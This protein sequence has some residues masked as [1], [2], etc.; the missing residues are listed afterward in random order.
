[1]PTPI[2]PADWFEDVLDFHKK[3]GCETN[4][5]PCYPHDKVRYLRA[6]LIREEMEELTYMVGCA[7]LTGIADGITDSIYVLIGMAMAYG[8]DLRPIWDEVHRTNMRKEGG[9]T[10]DDGKILKPNGWKPPRIKEL[11][12]EQD[13]IK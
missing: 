11:L 1:M 10:R 4:S 2:R 12:D 9:T 8:I 5:L 6:D 3:F 13:P 7:N